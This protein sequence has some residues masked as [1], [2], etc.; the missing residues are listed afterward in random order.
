MRFTGLK[1]CRSGAVV[2]LHTVSHPLHRCGL[3]LPAPLSSL[4][5]PLLL[6]ML[7]R[8]ADNHN[9]L[10][11]ISIPWEVYVNRPTQSIPISPMFPKPPSRKTSAPTRS[12]D[13]I[14]QRHTLA[15]THR[16]MSDSNVTSPMTGDGG[17]AM[18]FA[19]LCRLIS[20]GR[21]GEVQG[22]RDILDQ[23]NESPSLLLWLRSDLTECRK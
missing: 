16:M 8:S 13:S 18:T 22:I 15:E 14:T 10:K 12:P 5:L 9:R 21:A 19:T 17:E 4:L 3:P 6:V 20:E 11:G 2:L 23:I 1:M 7:L